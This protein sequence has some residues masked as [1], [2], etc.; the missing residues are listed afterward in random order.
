[1]RNIN[2]VKG[3]WLL[4]ALG[5][6][7]IGANGYADEG[8]LVFNKINLIE[9]Y[10]WAHVIRIY[11]KLDSSSNAKCDYGFLLGTRQF[12]PDGNTQYRINLN[13]QHLMTNNFQPSGPTEKSDAP[14]PSLSTFLDCSHKLLA[15][16]QAFNGTLRISWTDGNLHF[17]ENP[18][19]IVVSGEG[20][21]NI[22]L[23]FDGSSSHL[24]CSL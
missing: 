4:T 13:P 10:S 12:T 19:T 6:L 16:A 7:A 21:G 11:G 1:M 20:K 2:L 24:M 17:C 3:L 5:A 9:Y 22:R 14:S 8:S 23:T 15:L 18:D